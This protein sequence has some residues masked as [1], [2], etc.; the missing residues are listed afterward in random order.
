MLQKKN[1]RWKVKQ[2]TLKICWPPLRASKNSR[3]EKTWGG[4]WM[5]RSF[6]TSLLQRCRKIV[7]ANCKGKG[8]KKESEKKIWRR[9]GGCCLTGEEIEEK[10]GMK[11][12]SN[13]YILAN[14]QEPRILRLKRNG[15]GG[16]NRGGE[17]GLSLA[18]T[19]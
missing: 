19:G 10:D 17:L 7:V 2:G 9:F 4:G 1:E 18:K 3:G 8:S 16:F 5:R 12:K 15:G 14:L 13:S 6:Y 11:K